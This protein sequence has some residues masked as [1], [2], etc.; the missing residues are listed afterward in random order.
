MKK[1]KFLAIAALIALGLCSCTD[2]LDIQQHGVLNKTSYYKTDEDAN[3]VLTAVYK[4]ISGLELNSFLIKNILSDDIWCGCDSHEGDYWKINDYNFDS[5]N[6]NL[7]SLF[8]GYYNVIGKCNVVLDNLSGE[9]ETVRRA[10]A[11]ARVARAWM[12]FELTT[13]WGNPPLVDHLLGSDDSAQPNADP[14]ALWAFME[15]DLLDAINSGVLTQ[16]SSIDDNTVYHFTKQ[17]A[18]ALLGKVYLWEKKYTEAAKVLDEVINSGLYGLYQGEYVDIWSVHHEN[19]RESM[20]ESNFVVDESNPGQCMRLYPAF[21]GVHPALYDTKLGD[22]N[23]GPV[24]FSGNQPTSDLYNAFVSEEG[25]NGYRLNQTIKTPDFMAQHGYKF[26]DGMSLYGEGYYMWKNHMETDATGIGTPL[27]YG[28]NIRW[29][30]YSE[31]LLLAAEA[32]LG[33]GNQGKANQYLNEVRTRAKLPFKTCTLEAIK[34]EKQ[35]ELCNEC[36]RYQDLQRWGDA[37]QTLKNRGEVTPVFGADGKVVWKKF[38][39][40]YGY[41]V[42]KNEYLPYPASEIRINR[43]I[44]QNP[45]W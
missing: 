27:D 11:E 37:A 2:S 42:G 32:Q 44:K 10:Q 5:S 38:S 18:Q 33:A 41:K 20:F 7:E 29:M 31:V 8:S 4:D 34:K 12:Y 3:E 6:P 1:Y 19:N 17:Y 45:G 22:L 43:A 21:T 14:A 16:K 35:L 39:D 13:L 26:K 23:L 24:G 25:V 9:S 15:K 30:R 28:N 40:T 36:V